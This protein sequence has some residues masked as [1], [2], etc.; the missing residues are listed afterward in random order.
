M[1]R[2]CII[3]TWLNYLLPTQVVSM[4]Q[5]HNCCDTQRSLCLESGSNGF[6]FF[7]ILS[8][9]S[10]LLVCVIYLLSLS[11]KLTCAWYSWD[12]WCPLAFPEC[13]PLSYLQVFQNLCCAKSL[14]S[15]LTLCSSI[16]CSQTRLSMEFS[17]E[18]YWSG[19]PF[20]S[21][22]D[23]PDPGT[24]CMSPAL[25]GGFFTTSANREATH[26]WTFYSVFL[27]LSH[28]ISISLI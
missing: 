8:K 26:I 28:E 10:R 23:L 15:C 13:M 17:R 21:P 19:L 2:I 25:T 22:G 4:I 6:F 5:C 9:S 24:E 3:R 18:E 1:K 14:Q 7:V 12:F 16:D 11:Y 20:P 27:P